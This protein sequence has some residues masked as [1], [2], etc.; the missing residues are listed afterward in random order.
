[1]KFKPNNRG[2]YLPKETTATARQKDLPV[3]V[4]TNTFYGLRTI[5]KKNKKYT[6]EKPSFTP[7]DEDTYI[8]CEV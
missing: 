3:E 1:M 8:L 7:A 6:G 5:A 4:K 2:W